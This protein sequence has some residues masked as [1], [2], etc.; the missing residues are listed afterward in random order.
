[1]A[2]A[3]ELERWADTRSAQADLPILVRRLV[4]AENDQVQRVEMRGGEG[5]GLP[6]YDGFVEATRSTPFVPDG[7]SVWE[8]GVGG[9]PEKKAQSDYRARTDNPSGIDR[10]TT[11]FVFVTPRRWD[12]KKDWEQRRRD[13]QVWRD[14]RV[15]DADDLEQAL[16][17]SPAVQIWVSEL[18]GMDPLGATSI[19]DWWDRFSQGFRPKLTSSV[20]LAGREDQAAALTRRL[21]DEVGQTFIRA[22]SV[23]DG[24]A[25]AACSMMMM[26][27]ENSEQML[28]KSLL[29]HDGLTF[30]RLERTSSLL[31]LLPY[32]EH[33]QRDA[34]LIGN[35]H[36]VFVI[37]D[38]DGDVDVDLPSLDHLVL[39][40]ALK[41]AGV[42]DTDLDRYMRAGNKS[43]VALRRVSTQ[44]RD[45]KA[46]STDLARRP[47]RR[48]WLAGAWSGTRSGDA[49][50]MQT[51][52]ETDGDDFEESLTAAVRQPD[53]LFT[54][55][56]ATWAVASP[57][58][59]WRVARQFISDRDLHALERA[60]QT[61]LGAVD[62]RL[63]LPAED[64][65]LANIHGKSRIHSSDLRKGLGRSLALLGAYGDELWLSSG[66]SA[67]QWTER[68]A[69]NLFERAVKDD[70]AQLWTSMEDVLPLLAE[71]A[72]DHFL[73]ALSQS[74]T[75]ADPLAGKLFQDG[76]EHWN[77]GS[78]H[79]GFLWALEGLAWSEQYMGYA[80]EVLA[81]LAEIDPGGRLSNRPSASLEA[82]FRPWYP[83]TSAPL[84]TRVQTLDALARRHTDVAWDLLL[85]LIP[86]HSGIALQSH[87][88]EFRAWGGPS[89]P[90]VPR[91]EFVEMVRSVCDRVFSLAMDQP[92]R[93][94]SVLP[95][96]G[97]MPPEARQAALDNL[98]TLDPASLDNDVRLA[99]WAEIDRLV[100]RYREH[101]GAGGPLDDH[102]LAALANFREQVKPDRPSDVHRWLFDDWRPSIGVS[103]SNNPEAY[104][105]SLEAARRQAIREVYDA[106]GWDAVVALA[107][108]VEL[109]WA[110]GFS[111]AHVNDANDTLALSLLESPDRS[112]AQ[113][114]EGYAR[115]RLS[116]DLDRIRGW[117][118]RFADHPVL[119]ARLLQ[120]SDDVE[121]AWRELTEYGP[122]VDSVYWSEFVPYGRGSDFPLVNEVSR[123]LIEHGRV[124]MALH[125]LSMYVANRDDVDVDLIVDALEKFASID[126]P[127]SARVSDYEISQLL[128]YLKERGMED[129][130]IA[131]L[132]WRYLSLLR[133]DSRTL[134]LERLLARSP[135]TFVEM[136]KLVFRGRNDDADREPRDADRTLASNA[137]RLLSNWRIVPGRREDGIVDGDFLSGWIEEAR[138]LLADA[139]RVEVGE[140]QIG[141]VLAHAPED[142][143]GTFPALP[144]RD[145]LESAP[146]DR[147]E[148]GFSIGLFNRRGVT[149]RGLTEGGQQEYDLAAK[150]ESWASAVQA[151]HPRTASALRDVGEQYQEEG[152]RNDDEVRRYLEGLDL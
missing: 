124:A 126:E 98:Q 21:A 13:E 17:V 130:R 73:R 110:V 3:S 65:W 106:E 8:M 93:W 85:E 5:V 123:R 64:R 54:K 144:V 74:A 18:L 7:L 113:F 107:G 55:V 116:G 49:E 26:G 81:Q 23:D 80:A 109:P 111:L 62:P 79:T 69:W 33:L 121:G 6:G 101:P 134:A 120:L 142:P 146:S 136:V 88:P 125:A 150:Y 61:V 104:E 27:P 82:I 90:S 47:I 4:R 50:T 68:V 44:S 11:T 45:P 143:D 14:V 118:E 137:Y 1:M 147:L 34:H 132:E 66:R 108:T 36:V 57:E 151:T 112:Q 20:V 28:A 117:V 10:A 99:L 96:L 41:D 37:T 105:A 84:A 131:L 39:R 31:I 75:G 91:A 48:A 76:D 100:R 78:P 56:G 115:A 24:L 97:R 67:R 22:A 149:S 58:D 127:E 152:R 92:S 140:L 103:L 72:P 9:D 128:E 135:A 89:E 2:G 40:S 148:R 71:A 87:R 133:D 32:E 94:V 77:S 138:R 52:T 63:E 53:P 145:V 30:R 141:E 29:V 129:E 19:E 59:S 12:K 95:K 119:Q 42:P 46:W 139:D 15:L 51:L 35:H 83:Q 70:S 43:L 25:F 38:G 102:E 60:V 16:E 122:E 114:A 86:D